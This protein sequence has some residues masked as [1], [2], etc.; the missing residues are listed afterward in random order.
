MEL[1]IETN[2]KGSAY[3]LVIQGEVDLY[4]SP[5]MRECILNTIEQHHPQ[6]LLVDLTQVLY[7]D[8]SGIATLV[9]GLQLSNEYHIRFK[10]VGL[11]PTVLEVFELARLGRVFNIYTTEEEALR[12]I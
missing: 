11:S 6:T 5:T 9:E 3:I 10:L 8:S 12:D 7:M 4:S 2:V 1:S